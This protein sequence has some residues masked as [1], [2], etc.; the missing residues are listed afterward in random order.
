MTLE[1]LKSKIKYGDYVTVGE[2]IGCYPDKA[3]MR[4]R[5][6]NTKALEALQ[7]VIES[8]EQLIKDFQ[9]KNEAT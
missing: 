4:I 2:M 5:R 7:A 9:T 1:Q 8:R 3:K 6:N